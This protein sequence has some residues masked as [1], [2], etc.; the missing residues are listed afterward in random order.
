MNE[1]A[2]PNTGQ[3]G[4]PWGTPD[5][6]STQE[7]QNASSS[8][9]PENGAS[10][11]ST[12]TP[13]EAKAVTIKSSTPEI[14]NTDALLR[15]LSA[16]NEA[17]EEMTATLDKEL[18]L[19]VGMIEACGYDPGERVQPLLVAVQEQAAQLEKIL[20][21]LHEAIAAAHREVKAAQQRAEVTRIDNAKEMQPHLAA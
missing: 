15:F 6:Q 12:P 10:P 5:Q 2:E 19:S 21:P 17:V 18:A 11:N 14:A 20:T 3:P 1:P 16:R 4:Q 8:T 13:E 7:K 9:P